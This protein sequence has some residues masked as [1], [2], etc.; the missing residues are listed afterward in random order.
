M[1]RMGAAYRFQNLPILERY[2]MRTLRP[3]PPNI[4]KEH[5][6]CDARGQTDKTPVGNIS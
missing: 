4:G 5:K 6:S 2:A 3:F 1:P